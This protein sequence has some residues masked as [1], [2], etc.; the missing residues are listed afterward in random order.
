MC[1]PTLSDSRFVIAICLEMVGFGTQ[2]D[3]TTGIQGVIF[4]SVIIRIEKFLEPL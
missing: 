3:T 4:P 1:C 2:S